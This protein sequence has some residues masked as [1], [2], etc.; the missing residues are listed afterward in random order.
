MLDGE[1]FDLALDLVDMGVKVFPA[2][3]QILSDPNAKSWEVSRIFLV[4]RQIPGN[5]RQFIE[6]AV[7]RLTDSDEVVRR[8]AVR[9]L[10][11][12]GSISETSPVVAALS[13]S[14]TPV[15]Y[16][17][18]ESLSAIG[19]PREV[20]A[21]DVWL[22]GNS[23]RDDGELRRHVKQMRDKLQQR[24]VDQAKKTKS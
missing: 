17:A 2:F 1:E 24:L 21:F 18:A 13:D 14:K 7:K 15:V 23:H 20:A 8:T 5:R 11:E 3:E 19:G 4:V 12:I 10:G 9:L 16:F 22:N 6:H